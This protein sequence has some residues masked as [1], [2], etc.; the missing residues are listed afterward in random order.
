MGFN[1]VVDL[2][3]AMVIPVLASNIDYYLSAS[4]LCDPSDY[5]GEPKPIDPRCLDA[6]HRVVTLMVIG[7]ILGLVIRYVLFSYIDQ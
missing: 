3:L 6:R 1:I 2:F 7:A 5:G 4:Y